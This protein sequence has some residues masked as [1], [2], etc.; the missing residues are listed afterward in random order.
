VLK[1]HATVA[2]SKVRDWGGGRPNSVPLLARLVDSLEKIEQ[3]G[4]RGMLLT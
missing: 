2:A 1:H 4:R 3:K